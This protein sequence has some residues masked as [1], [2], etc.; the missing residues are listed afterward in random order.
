LTR[1]R[2]RRFRHCLAVCVVVATGL[3][4][5]AGLAQPTPTRVSARHHPWGRFEPGAWKLVRVVTETLDAQGQVVA[6]SISETKTTLMDI[7]DDEVTLEILAVA[8]VAGKRFGSEAQFVRQGF[9]GETLTENLQVKEPQAAELS[10]EGRKIACWTQQVAINGSAGETVV[11]IWYSDSLR[12]YYL[13]REARTTDPE[14]QKVLSHSTTEIVALDMPWRVVS[15]TKSA[16]LMRTVHRHA[17]GTTTTWAFTT[18][19][20]PGGVVS[21][22]SKETDE[23]GRVLRRST[24][25]LVGYGDECEPGRAGLFHRRRRPRLQ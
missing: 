17:K 3:A 15:E 22:S 13:R 7:D 5:V 23:T 24:L 16:S 18:P 4:P 6:T 1:P 20:V 9:H 21:H 2:C 12:P 25:E 10:V 19:N 14:S 11:D 8:E